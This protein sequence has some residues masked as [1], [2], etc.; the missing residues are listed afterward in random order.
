MSTTSLPDRLKVTKAALLE[1]D[2]L[3][4]VQIAQSCESNAAFALF[5]DAS[6]ELYSEQVNAHDGEVIKYLGDSCLAMFDEADCVKAIDCVTATRDAFP[7]ICDRFGIKSTGIRA[8]VHTGEVIY[9]KFGPE[10]QTDIL[11]R[12]ANE[13]FTTRGRGITI[14]EPVYRK[15]PSDRRGE[16][17]KHGGQVVYTLK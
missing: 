11:G 17:K 9:G 6:Y 4:T 16:W 1:M 13:L 7:A 10:G 8:T 2:I 3:N 5:L 15:L 14:T 12:S